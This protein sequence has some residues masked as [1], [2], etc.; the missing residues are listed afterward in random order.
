MENEYN[1]YLWPTDEDIANGVMDEYGCT[2]SADGKLLMK[3][4]EELTTYTIKEGTEAICAYA[5]QNCEMLENVTL[6]SSLKVIGIAAFIDCKSLKTVD[7]PF[8]LTT[9]KHDAFSNCMNLKN[10]VLPDS[11]THIEDNI[12]WHCHSLKRITLPKNLEYMAGN[13][14]PRNIEVT[15]NSD[16]FVVQD[17]MI[18]NKETNTLVT[19]I[20]EKEHI[21]IAEEIT[22]IGENAFETCKSIKCITLPQSV[23]EIQ[24]YAFYSCYALENIVLSKSLTII[25]NNAFEECI[26]LKNISLPPSLTT[27]SDYAFFR[28]YC[29]ENVVLPQALECIGNSVFTGCHLLRKVNLPASLKHIYKTSFDDGVEIIS[30]SPNFEI[31]DEFLIDRTHKK[32]L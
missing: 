27:I 12:F 25:D 6:P 1:N 20:Q 13:S 29:L 18:I 32:N 16:R 10:I 2:Y 28:C 19:C 30:D 31:T 15:S 14:I 9:I 22:T 23:T 26:S 17:G 24:S 11:V 3:A 8:G 7:L 21:S 5:F 4:N